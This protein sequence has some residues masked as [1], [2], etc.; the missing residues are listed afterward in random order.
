MEGKMIKKY[1][2]YVPIYSRK[3]YV[4]IGEDYK[5][6]NDKIN[7]DYSLTDIDNRADYLEAS[8]I[9]MSHKEDGLI[10]NIFLLPSSVE[11]YTIAHE[12]VHMA[13]SI[14]DLVGVKVE[15]DNNEALAYLVG[16]LMDHAIEII[17]KYNGNTKTKSN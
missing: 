12:C 17:D 15:A 7:K 3:V 11:P 5:K 6:I 9:I 14:L 16:H 1:H 10:D 2:F 8:T 4:Y 13:W